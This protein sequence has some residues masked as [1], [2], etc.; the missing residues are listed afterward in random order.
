M[1]LELSL[2]FVLL[3]LFHLTLLFLQ[4]H[5]RPSAIYPILIVSAHFLALVF[6]PLTNTC[7]PSGLGSGALNESFSN[8]TNNASWAYDNE[9]D[10]E[11]GLTEA[12]LSPPPPELLVTLLSLVLTTFGFYNMGSTLKILNMVVLL[13][14][15]LMAQIWLGV[16]DPID[17]VHLT[18]FVA[19]LGIHARETEAT[20]R[21]DFLWKMQAKG[22]NLVVILDFLLNGHQTI[23]FLG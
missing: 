13:V 21:L 12:C 2:V 22:E 14:I 17:S 4:N 16:L 23:L 9:T 7:A 8:L 20:G 1:S 10:L 15:H 11:L 5:L 19:A 6:I 3:L 18:L